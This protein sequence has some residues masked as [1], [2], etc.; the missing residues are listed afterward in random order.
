VVVDPALVLVCIEREAMEVPKVR[1]EYQLGID[2]TTAGTS[3]SV[4]MLKC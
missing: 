4:L 2:I 3:T 1:G